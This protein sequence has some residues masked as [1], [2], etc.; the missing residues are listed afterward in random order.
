[1]QNHKHLSAA[2]LRTIQNSQNI[3]LIPHQKPDGDCLGSVFA[4]YDYLKSLDKNI[5]VFCLDP[6]PTSLQFLPHS[7]T[8]TTDH[9]VFTKNYDAVIIFDSDPRYCGVENL[10]TAIPRS[11]TLINI[12]HH[13]SNTGHGDIS[14]VINTASST[15]EI[16][17][18]LFRDWQIKFN[19]RIATTLAT[20]LIT[21]TGGLTNPATNYQALSAIAHLIHEG[22]NPSQIVKAT[23]KN[24]TLP[25]LL[26]WGRALSR[27]HKI[28][29]YNLVY[30]FITQ[31]DF[32]ECEASEEDCEGISNYLHILQ[33]AQIILVLSETK[34]GLV[35]GSLRTTSS[36]NLSKLAQ[37]FGG[38]GHKK[39]SGF[40]LPGRLEYDNNRLRII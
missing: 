36:V 7:E 31:A 10:L 30:T 40:A 12:D 24:T 15:A 3:L 32:I 23:I 26:L 17:Y 9:L 19:E 14:L 37:F 35:K 13:A 22:A 4:F 33:D 28:S 39:A 2:I 20:G 5:T 18:R 11:F 38:G 25:N 1:M 27:L 34:N 29:R 8:L 16:I 21:D 6:V